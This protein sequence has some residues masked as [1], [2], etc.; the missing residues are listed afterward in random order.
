M[1]RDGQNRDV[2]D[3]RNAPR[4]IR[5]SKSTTHPDAH[6]IEMDLECAYVFPELPIVLAPVG[7]RLFRRGRRTS[8]VF[9]QVL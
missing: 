5:S 4:T 8:S 6:L 3:T 9:F 1:I 2:T 7:S